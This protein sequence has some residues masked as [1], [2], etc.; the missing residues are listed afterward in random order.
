[1][2]SEEI[3]KTHITTLVHCNPEVWCPNFAPTLQFE[4]IIPDFEERKIIGIYWLFPCRQ[5]TVM[6]CHLFS[7]TDKSS[8]NNHNNTI[9]T[10]THLLGFCFRNKQSLTNPYCITILDCSDGTHFH[11]CSSNYMKIAYF[12]CMTHFSQLWKGVE[13]FRSS[14][15]PHPLFSQ[16][17]YIAHPAINSCL[18]AIFLTLS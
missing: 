6:K 4:I 8:P 11:L 1:M 5:Q 9:K 16:H 13:S 15:H 3:W 18:W 10:S 12:L 7:L 17:P 14:P 2:N